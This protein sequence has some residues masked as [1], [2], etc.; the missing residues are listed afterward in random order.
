MTTRRIVTIVF[1]AVLL[2]IPFLLYWAYWYAYEAH[3]LFKRYR[4]LSD[5]GR[6]LRTIGLCGLVVY[7]AAWLLLVRYYRRGPAQPSAQLRP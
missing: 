6:H 3:F 1:G 4:W 2:A 7:A 5:L